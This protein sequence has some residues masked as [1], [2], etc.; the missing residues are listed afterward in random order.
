MKEKKEKTKKKEENQRE[1]R[2]RELNKPR[3]KN[4]YLKE[5]K[6]IR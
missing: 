4:S 6:H 2:E 3:K 5:T 1:T